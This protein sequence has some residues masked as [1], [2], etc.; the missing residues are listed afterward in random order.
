[1]P[2]PYSPPMHPN[3]QRFPHLPKEDQLNLMNKNLHF[4]LKNL[5]SH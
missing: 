3:K 2:N 4:L 5:P 1:M